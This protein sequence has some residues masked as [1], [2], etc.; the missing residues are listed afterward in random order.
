VPRLPDKGGRTLEV[1]LVRHGESTNNVAMSRVAEAASS[2]A[3]F[4]AAWLSQRVDDPG[5]TELG[6]RQAEVFAE[7]YGP[8]LRARGCVVYCSPL[9]RTLQTAAALAE[10]VQCEVRVRPDLFEIGGVYTISAGGVRGGPGRS[11]TSGEIAERFPSYNVSALPPAGPWYQAGWETDARGRARCADVAAWLR[12]EETRSQL[13]GR[14]LVIVCHGHFIDL[15]VKALL[16]LP[17]DATQDEP[18]TNNIFRRDVFF[19]SPNTSTTRLTIA[20]DG[21][22]QLHSFGDIGHLRVH[23]ASSSV[24]VAG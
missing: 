12:R 17:D 21:R 24:Q 15:L 4:E 1:L 11:L 18:N 2:K 7:A 10:R 14:V 8:D 23:G 5:L 13:D 19:H 16:G 3:E 20:D 6:A 9:L 22:V